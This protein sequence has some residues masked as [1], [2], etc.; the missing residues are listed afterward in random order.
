MVK[1]V[2][3]LL[4]TP[5]SPF[6]PRSGA[7]QRTAL[8]HEALAQE[9]DVDVLLLE[10]GDK[11]MVE[12][13]PDPRIIARARWRSLPL[14]IAKY[15]PDEVLTRQINQVA[16]LDR[17]DLIVSRYLNPL[18][19]L[20][21]PPGVRTL[22]DL[23]D[24]GY[25]YGGQAWWTPKGAL[26]R[27]KSAYAK[28]LARRQL[29]RFDAFFFVSERDRASEPGVKG[30][31]LPNIPFAPP[32]EPFPQSD[33]KNILFVGALWYGPNREG[34]QHFLKHCWGRIR[35]AVPDATLTLVGAAPQALR[36]EWENHPGVRAPGYVDSLDAAYREA[37]F[38][39]API[40]Y[41]GG[42]NIKILESLAYGRG[43]VTTPHGADAFITD[44]AINSGLKISRSDS[45][46]VDICVRWLCDVTARKARTD[47][48][49]KSSLDTYSREAFYIKVSQFLRSA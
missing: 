4:V 24:W 25:H 36:A 47:S 12:S 9:G 41:G 31:V 7:E 27:A 29:K 30:T 48:L 45:D 2:K 42:T 32:P 46:F 21:L 34:I 1:P 38:T 17:Y 6:T 11:T 5:A 40:Y 16:P 37:A 23:D 22:V 44:T 28:A 39:I 26:T 18:C 43:C 49:S 15:R 10:P 19:K 3:I 14:G 8:L 20:R 13:S 33:S 35:A